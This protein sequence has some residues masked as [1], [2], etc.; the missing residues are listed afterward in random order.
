MSPDSAHNAN[1]RLVKTFGSP[2]DT[3]KPVKLDINVQELSVP[4]VD[5]SGFS[6]SEGVVEYWDELGDLLGH[7]DPKT[8]QGHLLEVSDHSES[9]TFEIVPYDIASWK[10]ELLLHYSDSIA[11]DMICIDGRHNGWRYIL[12]PMALSDDLVMN[13]VLTTSAFHLATRKTSLSTWNGTAEMSLGECQAADY[14]FPELLYRRTIRSL[15]ERRD[16]VSGDDEANKSVLMAILVLLSAVQVNGGDEF[17][18]LYAM[19]R[20]LVDVLGGENRLCGSDLGDFMIRQMRK[21]R[22]YAAPLL[23]EDAGCG[24]FSSPDNWNQIFECLQFCSRQKPEHATCTALVADM[25]QQAHDIYLSEASHDPSMPHSFQL[26]EDS[27]CRLNR[28]RRSFEDFPDDAPGKHA[29]VWP[30]FIA[31]SCSILD[32]HKE[33]FKAALLRF[34]SRSRFNNIL[35]GLEHLQYLWDRRNQGERWTQLLAQSRFFM[36]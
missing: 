32:E 13:A 34:H 9:L 3:S 27:I 20:A 2:N 16:V 33:F 29:L 7:G 19:M 5:S 26:F 28:F 24:T 8:N 35:R 4:L 17:P 11:G 6:S 25:L 1:S 15:K 30:T 18:T 21:M 31:A 22:V 10:R 23:S 12:L 14:S 36:A